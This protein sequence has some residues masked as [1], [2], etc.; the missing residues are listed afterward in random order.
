MSYE[1]IDEDTY[2]KLVKKVKPI[3]MAKVY[4]GSALDFEMEKFCTSDHCEI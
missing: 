1:T 3:E 2:A 4:E